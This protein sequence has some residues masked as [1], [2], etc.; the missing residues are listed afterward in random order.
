M[1]I[2]E[3]YEFDLN[4]Y[5]VY[6]NILSQS[7]VSRMNSILESCKLSKNTGKFSFFTLDPCFIELMS[8]PFTPAILRVMLGAW[9]RFD[10]A[11]GIEMTQTSSAKQKLHA[12]PMKEQGAFFYQWV[13]GQMRNGLI[14]VI[15]ALSDIN[16][17]DGGFV[18]VPGSH[19][20]NLNHYPQENSHLVINPALKAG[21]MLIFTEALVHGS[22]KWTAT[23]T[24]RVLIYSYAPGCLAW[25]NYD[26]IKSYQEFATNDLQRDLLR[27]PNV[28]DYDE[29]LSEQVGEV[30][31]VFRSRI[32]FNS[33][34]IPQKDKLIH[35]IIRKF[36]KLISS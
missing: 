25:R 2:D 29:I 6:R 23:H 19:K 7:D 20:A 17:G 14:K 27:P 26:S 21:D 24:R 10:H 3:M 1:T 32:Q 13:Q 34:L 11:F 16:S 35:K 28:G 18:C 30:S 8:H 15:Y 12:G 22:R 33:L 4:G 9:V 31:N 36:I 5:I